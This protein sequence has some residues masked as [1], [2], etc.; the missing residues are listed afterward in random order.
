MNQKVALVIGAS[1]ESV[2]A[3]NE[4]KKAGL[5]VVAFDGNKDAIG[6]KLADISYVVDIRDPKNIIEKLTGGGYEPITI[7]PVPIG[8]Y[9]ITTG[10]INDYYKLG[11][12][13]YKAADLCTDKL[14][15]HKKLRN[16]TD[17]TIGG[18]LSLDKGEDLRPIECHLITPNLDSSILKFPLIIKP[19][20]GSGSRD[21]IAVKNQDEFKNTLSKID[22][23]KEDFLAETLVEGTEYGLSGAVINGVY[24]HILIREKLL[25]P[26]PYRQSIGNL[27]A[28]EISEVSRYMQ[29]VATRLNLKN[30]L[31][32]ADLIVTPE[33]EP[34]IIEL[35]PRPSGHYLS[36]TFVEIATGVNMTKEWINMILSK[37]FSF[38]P[39]FTKHA[40][41]RYFDF[42]GRVIP[43]NF[44]ILKEELGIVKYECN[45]NGVLG[46]VTD[47]AS[48]MNRG[49]A[50]IVANNKQECLANTDALIKKF[51]KEI[52]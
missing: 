22:L 19:R 45:I 23:S 32:N 18:G 17:E 38:E 41:I 15:F 16:L 13:S 35:A 50:I 5:K 52:K 14:L 46:I 42:E 27:S 3:I 4:A 29:R 48:I 37:P 10:S 26:L 40:I 49:Y 7:L 21:V 47:G 12:V 36:S 44:E 28:S 30:C 8:R 6:L 20:F 9:L 24:I 25:T 31:I 43:P 51:K 33:G 11:G 34:F 39:K 1:S 2:F